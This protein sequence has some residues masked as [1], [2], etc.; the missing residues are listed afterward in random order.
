MTD[1]VNGFQPESEEQNL[2][3]DKYQVERMLR[4]ALIDRARISIYQLAREK[5]IS[6]ELA[7]ELVERLDFD[8]IRFS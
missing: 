1:F 6:D 7:R 8:H 5:K 4:L 3:Y 2:E